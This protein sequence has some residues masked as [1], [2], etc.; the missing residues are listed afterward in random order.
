MKSILVVDDSPAELKLI[1]S[2]LEGPLDGYRILTAEDGEQ[3]LEQATEHLPAVIVLDVVLPKKNG[4]Q[5]C[6]QLKTN[7]QTRDIKVILVTNKKQDSDRF[8]GMK[9]G[10]DEY[11]TKPFLPQDLIASVQ[12]NLQV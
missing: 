5:V 1:Q 2:V 10:A 4:Y 7:S 3:A 6:R 8:W 9:Q 11:I 12:R